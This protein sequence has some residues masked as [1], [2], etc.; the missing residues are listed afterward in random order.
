[1][2]LSYD[3]SALVK[4]YVVESGSHEMKRY[5]EESEAVAVCRISWAEA[6]AAFS[7]RAREVSEDSELIENAKGALWND[8]PHFMVME[9][10]QGLVERA[11]EYADGFALRAYDALQTR[12]RI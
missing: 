5:V 1:M 7:R 8:W 2:T 11:G 6:H 10:T 9:I 3:T 4:L 12:R